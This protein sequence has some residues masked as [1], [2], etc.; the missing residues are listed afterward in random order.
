[1][2]ACVWVCCIAIDVYRLA[3]HY[4]LCDFERAGEYARNL[5]CVFSRATRILG[6]AFLVSAKKR[7]FFTLRRNEAYMHVDGVYPGLGNLG[8]RDRRYRNDGC[9]RVRSRIYAL[10]ALLSVCRLVRN[11]SLAINQQNCSSCQK[12]TQKNAGK[13]YE[14]NSRVE[15]GYSH[16]T[17]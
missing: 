16:Q 4:L 15:S 7:N 17:S 14:R 3:E 8:I 2:Y 1:M 6:A 11:Q 13:R 12:W 9:T 10:L 5:P